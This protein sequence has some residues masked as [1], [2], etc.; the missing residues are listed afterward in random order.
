MGLA[1]RINIVLQTCFF[2]ISGVL[3]RDESIAKIKAAIEK[4][5]GRRG[6]EVVEKNWAAVDQAL[7]GLHQVEVPDGVTTTRELPPP[8]PA[9]ASEFVRS[10]TAEMMA[11]RGDELPVSALRWTAPTRAADGVREAQHLRAGRGM[12]RRHLHPVRQL[13]LRLPAHRDP[14]QVLDPASLEGAPDRFQSAPLGGPGLPDAGYSLQVDVEDCT[15]CGLCVEACPVT[16]P[17][18]P[19]RKAI[20]LG[21]REPLVPRRARTS[22]SSRRCR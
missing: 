1:G 16:V 17:G 2:A 18:D 12:G 22:R 9:E 3:P 13:Q 4:T 20:N 11:G 19:V 21:Q 5:Y 10:V 6:P 15:G 8:V 14:L 7:A